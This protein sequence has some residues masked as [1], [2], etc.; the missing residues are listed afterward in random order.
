M[1][2]K[3]PFL[4]MTLLVRNEED[5]IAENIL[6]H[7]HMGVDFFIVTDNGS[8]DSTRDILLQFQQQG[9]LVL[10][11]EP[12]DTY[13][14]WK[15]V[16]RMARMAHD[17]L[18]AEWVIH[19]DADE[20][21]TAR[22][23]NLKLIFKTLPCDIN[24]V[25][26]RRHDFAYRVDDPRPWHEALIYRKRRS[27]NHIGLPLPPKV[28]HRAAPGIVVT[29][30][31]H[32]VSGVE[33]RACMPPTLEILHF[34][35]RSLAQ[36]EKKIACGGAAYERNT[37]IPKTLGRGWRRLY[38]LLKEQGSLKSYLDAYGYTQSEIHEALLRGELI[39]DCRIRDFIRSH[40]QLPWKAGCNADAQ[41]L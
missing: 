9:I 24:T 15:W 8:S 33:K 14:Q 34:P 21:W 28:A 19:S 22:G 4:V 31:N 11:D 6:Y 40:P 38:R 36:F 1:S 37:E 25:Y 29:Q 26:V 23:G 7:I 32:D 41:G 2:R 16:T 20:F 3:S 30:G 35:V 17:D 18:K 5:I 39:E 13:N 27:L 10:I 12:E